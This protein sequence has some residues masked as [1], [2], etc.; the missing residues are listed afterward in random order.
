MTENKI[1][2]IY[3]NFDPDS[4]ISIVRIQ[5]PEGVFKGKARLHPKDRDVASHFA[6]CKY[7][8]MRAY[9]KY[10]TFMAKLKQS[11]VDE[12]RKLNNQLTQDKTVPKRVKRWSSDQLASLTQDYNIYRAAAAELKKEISLQIQERDKIL[13]KINKQKAKIE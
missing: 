7:A 5:T 3:S 12:L 6:G 13:D 9:V 4:G 10:Y 2:L 1:K 8:E 11:A